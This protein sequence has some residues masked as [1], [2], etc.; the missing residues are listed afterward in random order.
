MPNHPTKTWYILI[1][2]NSYDDDQLNNL[3]YSAS[4]CEALEAVFTDCIEPLTQEFEFIVLHDRTDSNRLPIKK[5]VE[6]ILER[7][8][9]EVKSNHRI[10]FYFCGHGD[11]DCENQTVLCLRNTKCSQLRETGLV[12]QELFTRLADLRCEQTIVLIDACYSGNLN[13]SNLILEKVGG[14]FSCGN[15]QKSLQFPFLGHSI[16][17]YYLIESLRELGKD[18]PKISISGI[19]DYLFERL[20]RYLDQLN[21]RSQCMEQLELMVI[22]NLGQNC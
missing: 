8:N 17:S 12:L 10:V 1:G 15:E 22:S 19:Y 4:D 21:T 13:D 18:N 7:L 6:S 2:V 20:T 9:K 16:F 5:E 14:L 11:R 3:P